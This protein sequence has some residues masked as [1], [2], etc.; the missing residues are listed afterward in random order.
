MEKKVDNIN[1]FPVLIEGFKDGKIIAYCLV[2]VQKDKGMVEL[3]EFEP[4]LFDSISNDGELK[5]GK[6]I[7]LSVISGQGFVEINTVDYDLGEK[8]KRHIELIKNATT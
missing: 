4:I 5:R 1:I 3:R 8:S 2:G 6:L 7:Y